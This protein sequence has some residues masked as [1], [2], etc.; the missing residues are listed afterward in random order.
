MWFKEKDHVTAVP[1][2]H[3]RTLVA[4]PATM[5]GRNEGRNLRETVVESVVGGKN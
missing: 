1:L 4:T 2:E 5:G 3:D